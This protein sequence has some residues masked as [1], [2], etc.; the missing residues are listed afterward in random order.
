M[1][2]LSEGLWLSGRIYAFHVEDARFSP[3]GAPVKRKPWKVAAQW[4]QR[5]LS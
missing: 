5:V 2:V 4:R 3:W 1:C